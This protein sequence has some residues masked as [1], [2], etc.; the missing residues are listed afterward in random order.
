[1]KKWVGIDQW[2]EANDLEGNSL[3]KPMSVAK[4]LAAMEKQKFSKKDVEEVADHE[5]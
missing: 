3:W 5:V 4:E 2:F 1:M